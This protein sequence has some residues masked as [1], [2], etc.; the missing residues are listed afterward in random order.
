LKWTLHPSCHPPTSRPGCPARRDALISATSTTLCHRCSRTAA[1]FLGNQ[2]GRTTRS[3]PW[4]IA[5][6]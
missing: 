6:T 1:W 5:M 3:S 4:R 2:L